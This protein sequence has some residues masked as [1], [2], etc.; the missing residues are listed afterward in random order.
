MN[1]V[2]LL[3]IITSKIYYT[4]QGYLLYNTYSS[5]TNLLQRG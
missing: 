5:D 1:L 3:L 4:Y 2:N